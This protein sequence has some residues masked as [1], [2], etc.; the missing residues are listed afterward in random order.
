[1]CD[2]HLS[3]H[4]QVYL[5]LGWEGEKLIRL[6]YIWQREYMIVKTT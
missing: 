3:G 1:M 2:D 6:E 5:D 4:P